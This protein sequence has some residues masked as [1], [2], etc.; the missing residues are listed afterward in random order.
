L[1]VIAN[2][3]TEMNNNENLTKFGFMILWFYVVMS[4]HPGWASLHLLQFSIFHKIMN[5]KSI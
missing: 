2:R 1:Q 3:I 4:R 5:I